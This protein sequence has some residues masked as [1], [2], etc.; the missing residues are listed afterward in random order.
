MSKI[1]RQVKGTLRF[2]VCGACPESVLNACAMQAVEL[3]ELESIDKCTLRVT[4]F[5][6]RAEEFQ[7]LARR[8]M[9]ETEK[10]S[11]RGGSKSRK[12]IKRRRA[13]LLFALLTAGLLLLSSLFIWDIQVQGCR[14]LSPGRVLRA[15]SDCGVEQGSF[16]FGVNSDMVRSRVMVE[17]PEI[18]WMTVN[19]RGSRA[20]VLVMEREEKPEIYAEAEASDLVAAK[21]GIVKSLSVLSGK[22]LVRPGQA[23]TAGETLVSGTVDSIT[24]QPRQLRSSGSVTAETWTEISALRPA[25]EQQKTGETKKSFR[26]ALKFGEKRINLYV[27]GRNALDECDKIVYEY[28][29]GIEGLFLLPVSIIK[30]ELSFYQTETG[31]SAAGEE[32]KAALLAYLRQTVDGEVLE[33]DFSFSD[34]GELLCVTLYAHCLEN[35]AETREIEQEESGVSPPEKD[36]R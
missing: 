35:I 25:S 32:M 34:G 21:T 10:L 12:L 22:T 9:C 30:E 14:T 8:C 36:R 27:S 2:E 3:M 29:L 23:V 26:F 7:A 20:T 6:N 5:E 15:L 13:L 11:Q 24:A 17:L 28:K 4:V 19:V 33:T 1:D 16:R 31:P 18:A